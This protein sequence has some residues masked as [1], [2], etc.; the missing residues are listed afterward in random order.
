MGYREAK[1]FLESCTVGSS[2][3]ARIRRKVEVLA[4]RERSSERHMDPGSNL[5]RSGL[6][7]VLT[8]SCPPLLDFEEDKKAKAP[9]VRKGKG[10]I[11]SQHDDFDLTE[12]R[13]TRY[14]QLKNSRCMQEVAMLTERLD[15][16]LEQIDLTQAI[17]ILLYLDTISLTHEMIQVSNLGSVLSKAR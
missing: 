7:K 13:R 3:M 9:A 2:G 12:L 10:A 11:L 14:N 6:H 15:S 1:T 8:F 16:A 17:L 4:G 5:S